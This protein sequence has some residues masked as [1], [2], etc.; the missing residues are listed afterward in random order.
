MTFLLDTNTCVFWLRGSST[1]RQRLAAV[2][3]EAIAISTI[4]LAE[5]RYGAE[6]SAQP[7]ANH[8]AIDDFMSGVDLIDVGVE[9]AR[10]FG[11]VKALLRRQGNLI[12]DFDLLLAATALAHQM[13]LVTNNMHHFGR[14]PQLVTENWSQG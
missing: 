13:T 5:L 3:Q 7:V 2:G 1:V 9:T 14:V 6:W 11:V 4:T 8:R 12:E 10:H